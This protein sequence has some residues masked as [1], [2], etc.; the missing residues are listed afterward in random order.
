MSD[1]ILIVGGGIAGIQA[2]LDAAEAGAK[3]VLVEKGPVIG[4]VMALLDK[5]FPTLDCSICIEGP[6]IGEVIR[7]P[8]IEVITMADVIGLEGEPGN[9]TVTIYQRPRYVTE[10]CTKCG[11]CTDVCPV[12]VPFEVDGGRGLSLR[13]AIYLPYPQAEPGWY[14]VDINACLNNPPGY[15]PCDRCIRVCERDAIDFSMGPKILKKDVASI[16]VA[17]GYGLLDPSKIQI[18]KYGKL[19]DV[20]TSFEFDRLLNASGP[21]GGEVIRP[22]D[23]K[24]VKK[25]LF[26]ACVGS[27]DVNWVDYCSRFCCMYTLK[28][29]LQAKQHGVEDITTLFMDIRAFGKGFEHFY[30]RAIEE[31]VKVVRGRSA[32][33]RQVD[34]AI[35]VTYEDTLTG[36]IVEEDFDMV[37]LAPA[38]IANKDMI[39]L[40]KAL[41]IELDVD[42]FIKLGSPE[43]PVSTTKPGIYVCGGASG[44]KDIAD[45]VQEAG[46]AVVR[47]LM[48]VEKL[49]V[50]PKEFKETITDVD[51]PR[52]GVFVCHCGSNIAGVVDVKKAVEVAKKM[53]NVVYAEDLKFACSAA[54]VEYIADVIRENNLNRIIVAACSPA[55]HLGV[56]RTA[57]E[58]AGLNPFLVDMANVRNLDSWV[59]ANEPEAATIK[60]I[61]YIKAAVERSPYLIPLQMIK[62]P[63]VKRILVIGGGIAGMYAASAAARVGIETVLVEKDDRL[64]GVL[65]HLYRIAPEGTSAEEILERAI[66]EVKESGVKVYLGTM[67]E[68]IEGFAGQFNVKL[69][70]GESI[71]V[72]A[73]ILATGVKPHIPVEWGYGS[74]SRL[75]TL[76]DVE[77]SKYEVDGDNIVFVG[78]IGSRNNGRGCSRYCCT[79]MIHQAIELRKRGK[80][81]AIVYKD[82]RTYT[83]YAERLYREAAKQ[84]VLFIKVNNLKPMEEN[85]RI[86]N[87]HIIVRDELSGDEVQVPADKIV[88]ATALDANTE[89]DTLL[90][91]L[92]VSKDAEG[93][94]LESHPKLGPVESLVP[95]IFLAGSSQGPKDILETMAHSL[96]AAAKAVSLLSKG[97]IEKE[98]LI[99]SIDQ[100]KC[101]KCGACMRACPYG[102]I[103]GEVKKHVY[104]VPALC[105]GCGACLGECPINAIRM[106]GFN[107]EDIY[108]MLEA[109]LSEEPEKKPIAFTCYWCSYA[110]A[111]NA[112]IFKLQY[113]SSPRVI[114]LPC[115]SRVNWRLVKKA[116]LL[117]APAVAVTGCRITETGSDCH[118]QYANKH[119]LR[120]FRSMQAI[121]KRQGIAENRLI[122]RLFGA[123]DVDKFVDT[124]N[125]LDKIAKSV[126]KEEIEETI[127]KLEKV[128]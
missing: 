101:I 61:D 96:A 1:T 46:A 65:N 18:Y 14:V 43:D 94:L 9:F 103:K 110:A 38:A 47:A 88:L 119:T 30:K 31:G 23:N 63:V 42:G 114:R 87:G 41:G 55:T 79:S 25:I 57:A 19:P 100:E 122:L 40:S 105:E 116:F 49:E 11:Y 28:H 124:M 56:F 62:V 16:I 89:A 58:M 27:R 8:N 81:V 125:E 69:S 32:E 128:K 6:K 50:K 51:K 29:A 2:A 120:R 13:K 59:H 95:G 121:L 66:Q 64:G 7:H 3:V 82:I 113:P 102:A 37:V 77:K 33:F 91:Q 112:G 74:D 75:L 17:T 44:P 73:I 85:V 97:Y 90:E 78:C 127:R 106:P 76:L 52:I 45:S 71:D 118:Y 115:S 35:R 48:H 68:K 86:A 34:G 72:G 93:F 54:S 20:L 36:K 111:D 99:A 67:V 98:P 4:G 104:V 24:H 15:M 53:P 39:N 84:G 21:S 10:D 92:K 123:P 80:N 117:G 70:N 60:A 5:T 109:M 126:S 108:R 12:S 107:D 22:S 26:V 83:R